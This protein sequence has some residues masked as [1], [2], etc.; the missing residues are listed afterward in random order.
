M[1]W[2]PG[3]GYAC[4]WTVAVHNMN[5]YIGVMSKRGLQ[6]T[7]L[8]VDLKREFNVA[9]SAQGRTQKSVVLEAVALFVADHKAAKQAA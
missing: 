3:G 7:D 2:T 8:G 4:P 5:S 9:C 1:L 6:I